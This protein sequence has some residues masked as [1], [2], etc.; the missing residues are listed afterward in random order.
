M[1][2][3]PLGARPTD[4]ATTQTIEGDTV[5]FIVRVESGTI[6]RSIYRIAVLDDPVEADRW[7]PAM[8][9]PRRLSLC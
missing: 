1:L 8:E 3:D 2:A 4:L 6:N 7:N 9:P 5:P